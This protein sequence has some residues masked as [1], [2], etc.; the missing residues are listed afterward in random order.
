M[1]K[2]NNALMSSAQYTTRIPYMGRIFMFDGTPPTAADV[3]YALEVSKEIGYHASYPGTL[4]PLKF[5]NW[6]IGRGNAYLGSSNVDAAI[7]RENI[8]EFLSSYPLSRNTLSFEELVDGGE[9]TWF[10]Y[11]VSTS[12][13]WTNSNASYLIVHSIAGTMGG[14]GSGADMILPGGIIDANVSL[15]T[16]DINI[17]E[18]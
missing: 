14:E 17:E 6:A 18:I 16:N 2:F 9:P 12:A 4:S 5:K 11:M 1:I 13:S 10:I 7:V 3:K 8:D 15:K